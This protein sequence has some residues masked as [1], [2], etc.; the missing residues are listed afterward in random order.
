MGLFYRY[1][2]K[3]SGVICE[4]GN[5][6]P[7]FQH[8]WSRVCVC[9][10]VP[11]L[12]CSGSVGVSSRAVL[13][14]ARRGEGQAQPFPGSSHIPRAAPP[15]GPHQELQLLLQFLCSP[16]RGTIRNL[17]WQSSCVTCPEGTQVLEGNCVHKSALVRVFCWF[18]LRI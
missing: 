7:V 4:L 5:T 14:R 17:S 9:V 18:S 16:K 1:F 2:Y 13:L 12:S 11:C 15:A 3:L 10:C 8:S 6:F